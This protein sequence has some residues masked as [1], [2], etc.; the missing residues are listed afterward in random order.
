MDFSGEYRIPAPRQTVWEALNDPEVLK[1]CIDGCESLEKV[2]DTEL[3]AR[4]KAKVGPVSAKF[5]GTVTLS[6][7]NPPESYVISGQGQ[8]GAAGFVKGSATVTLTEDG[9]DA[10]VLRYASQATVGGKLA[11]VGGRLVK[12][13][14][15]KTADDFFRTFSETVA[16]APVHPHED[17]ISVPDSEADSAAA[18]EVATETAPAPPPIREEVPTPGP[19]DLPPAKVPPQETPPPVRIALNGQ[20][21]AVALGWAALVIA[22]LVGLI[23]LVS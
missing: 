13:V 19:T 11:S 14:A 15:N 16:G 18:R 1:Q 5:A 12:G 22:A 9:P 17:A 4:I 7:M 10:T 20:T 23:W 8:G 3:T 2:T 21:I 6:D